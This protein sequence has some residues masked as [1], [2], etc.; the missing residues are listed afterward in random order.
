VAADDHN[1]D[2][3]FGAATSVDGS[4]GTPV[5]TSVAGSGVKSSS[6]PPLSAVPRDGDDQESSVDSGHQL[7]TGA[8]LF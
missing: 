6:A 8:C 4:D 5:M 3:K 1:A 2:K 7:A